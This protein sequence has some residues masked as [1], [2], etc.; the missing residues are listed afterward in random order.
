MQYRRFGQTELQMPVLSCG[1]MRYQ[2]SWQDLEPSEIDPKGQANLEETI[3]TAIAH[4]INH[5]ETARGYGTS[6]YQLGH[7]LPSLPRDKIIV[8]TKIGPH[9]SENEFLE[10]FE[11]SLSFLKLDYVDLLSVH[12]INNDELLT[13]TL[14]KGTLDACR[15]LQKQGRARHIGFSTH[16]PTPDLLID[17][18]ATG[19]FA[20]IN[21]H[22]YYFDQRNW[23][24]I[25]AATERDMG[26]FIISPSDKGGKLFDP[27]DKL[28]ELCRPLTPMG[29]NDLFCL[30][31]PQVHTLS[32]GAS[33]PSDFDAHMA[34]IK[35]LDN[36]C[37]HLALIQER[38]A[39]AL[40]EALGADW[41]DNWY[42]QLPSMV[43]APEQLPVYHILR[44]YTLVKAYDML[45]FGKMRYNLL[46][47]A[48]HW[49]PGVKA[50]TFDEQQLLDGLGDYPFADRVPEILRE[51]HALLNEA[52]LKRASES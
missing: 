36:P 27:P 22:W 10:V 17:A 35:D 46:G 23:P 5:I 47:N 44:M 30:S 37:A 39:F 1:G 50:S 45:D 21:L 4:G 3:H 25:E 52:D 12:G 34:I 42:R 7:V 33:R 2:Q 49:F 19:E 16:A 38:L 26:V 9:D 6:E 48:D 31:H 32:L 8:Q 20:Y 29:F 14:T 11:K 24:A 15:T 41:A 40:R 18:I 43:N 28:T 51:T 13:Q